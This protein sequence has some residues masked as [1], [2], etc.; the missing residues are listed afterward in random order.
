MNVA[1]KAREIFTG[2]EILTNKAILVKD[3]TVTA[4]VPVPDIPMDYRINDLSEYLLAPA[5]IDMQIY[6][7]NGKLFS[8]ELTT[9][10]LEATYEYGLQGGCTHFMITMATNSIEKFFKGIEVVKKYWDEGGNGLLG[11]HLE[12]PYINPIKKG[13]HILKFI[14]KPTAD[15]VKMLLKKGKGIFKM[16]TI[17]PEQCDQEIIDL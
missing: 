9:D 7:G 10:S 4:I 16:M 8:S 6:G 17:A 3:K 1:Y 13:A 14:K 12:G 15:E 11:L 2:Y 5:Y